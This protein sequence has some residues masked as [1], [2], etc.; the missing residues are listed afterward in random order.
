MYWI[1][2]LLSLL[3]ILVALF[4]WLGRRSVLYKDV[5]LAKLD[6]F[7]D[8][9]MDCFPG[10]V[11]FIRPMN[12]PGFIQFLRLN[13]S[14]GSSLHFGFPD[15]PWSRDY[16]EPLQHA[17]QRKGIRYKIVTT[18]EEDIRKFL[19][20]EFSDD[21]DLA[22]EIVRICMSVLGVSDSERFQVNIDGAI[23]PLKSRNRKEHCVPTR[24]R[25]TGGS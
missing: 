2:L 15:A 14:E 17:V 4:W 1:L 10:S 18:G 21:W 6:E 24:R 3:A 20:I 8:T 13:E 12:H 23:D 11:L 22:L 5:P 9:L 19:V 25:S 7:F 16:F